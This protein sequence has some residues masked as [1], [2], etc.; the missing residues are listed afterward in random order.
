[1]PLSSCDLDALTQRRDAIRHQLAQLGDLRPGSLKSRFRRCG[2][3]RCRC[4]REG[5]PGHGPSWFLS[6][7]VKGKMHCRGIPLH[8]LEDTRRQ[9][10]ECQRLRDLTRELMEVNDRICE[11]RLNAHRRPPTPKKGASKPRSGRR[12]T[13]KSSG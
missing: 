13:R 7:I 1:M 3:S 8:A 4:A 5:H 12:V 11:L 9:V 6:R 2:R 10:H